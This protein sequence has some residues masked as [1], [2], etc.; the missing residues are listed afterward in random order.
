MERFKKQI[1]SLEGGIIEGDKLPEECTHIVVPPGQATPKTTAG[2]LLGK[3]LVTP[4]WVQA[5]FEANKWLPE[6]P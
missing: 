5:C 3:W 6:D 4:D 2:C 1:I